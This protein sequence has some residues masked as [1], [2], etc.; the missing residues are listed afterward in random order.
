[1][2]IILIPMLPWL[3]YY[4]SSLLGLLPGF[5]ASYEVSKKV[6]KIHKFRLV[7]SFLFI[8]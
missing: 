1:M 8:L 7:I 4:Y 6:A 2:W 5:R 3:P